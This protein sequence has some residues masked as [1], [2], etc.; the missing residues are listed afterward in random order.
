MSRISFER[1]VNGHVKRT[2]SQA[3]VYRVRAQVGPPPTIARLPRPA[4]VNRLIIARVVAA[5]LAALPRCSGFWAGVQVPG[6]DQGSPR[7]REA[8]PGRLS[9]EVEVVGCGRNRV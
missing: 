6:P 1:P 4:L 3:H 7:P 9:E 8:G 2:Y 5:R